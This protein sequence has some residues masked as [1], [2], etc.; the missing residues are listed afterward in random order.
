MAAGRERCPRRAASSP[1]SRRREFK[2]LRETDG[3]RAP[4][5]RLARGQS[6]ARTAPAAT[7][8]GRRARYA[9]NRVPPRRAGRR[10]GERSG[11]AC[12]IRTETRNR[13]SRTRERSGEGR[14][15][16]GGRADRMASHP[17][18]QQSPRPPSRGPSMTPD[19]AAAGRGW[20]EP[21]RPAPAPDPGPPREP[22]LDPGSGA[23]VTRRGGSEHDKT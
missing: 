22:R 11:T 2:N 3:R 20:T 16:G 17:G 4:C 18:P 23:G 12:S 10:R 9:R 5:A 21:P 1:G 6:G 19:T 8:A 13:L 14:R 15:P 7:R